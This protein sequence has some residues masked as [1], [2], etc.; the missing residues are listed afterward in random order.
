MHGSPAI[1]AFNQYYEARAYW[2]GPFS[3]RP[4]DL[5][6]IIY[7]RNETSKYVSHLTSAYSQ[8]TSLFANQNATSVT[9]SYMFHVSP[10][11]YATVGLGYTDHPSIQYFKA[12]GSALQFL[13]SMYINL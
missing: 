13:F 3:S 8:Y 1:A 9:V 11:L 7:N 4:Q 12:E 2:L 5:L 10:G 6:S